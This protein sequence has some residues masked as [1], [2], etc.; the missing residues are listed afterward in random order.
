MRRVLAER[1]RDVDARLK[2]M[3]M[4]RSALQEHLQ[5][6][7]EALAE[8]SEPACPSLNALVG[9]GPGTGSGGYDT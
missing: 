8:R 6:C 7:D 9:A 1:L 3:Q 4:F 5:A 2:E